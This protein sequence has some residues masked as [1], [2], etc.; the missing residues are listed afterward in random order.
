VPKLTKSRIDA[1]PIPESGQASHWDSELRGFG[2]RVLPSGLKT[3]VLQYRNAEAR[4]RRITLARVGVLTI[5]QARVEAR[6]KL[7]EIARGCDPIDTR[8]AARA[9]PTVADICDWY[10]E[11]AESGRLLGRR[12]LPIKASSLRMD[13]SRIERH[14]KPLIGSRKVGSLTPPDIAAM[15]AD[16]AAGKSSRSRGAGRGRDTTGGVGAGSRTISTLHAVFGH[17]VRLG[18]IAVNPAH[19]VRRLAAGQRTRRLSAA[20]IGALGDAMRQAAERGEHP[21]GL[22]AVRLI[23]LTGFRRNEAQALQRAWVDR[24]ADCV[25]F[26]DTKS[27]AQV[28]VVGAAAMELI[29]AQPEQ[30]G[31]P[32]VFPSDWTGTYYKQVPDIVTRLCHAAQVE[33]VT[34]HVFRHTFASI[35]GELGYSELTIAGL[36]GHGKRGV[37]QGY[38]HIDELL[39]SAADAVSTKIAAILDGKEQQIAT[40]R[41]SMP[42]PQV[43][44]LIRSSATDAVDDNMLLATLAAQFANGGIDA[45]QLRAAIGRIAA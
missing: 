25:M 29:E 41:K 34:P 4:S 12:R 11:E 42:K 26:P 14:I 2:V 16:I 37:T 43:Q 38:I 24:E 23:L 45:D 33:G 35:A 1:F 20:E 39:R 21:V 3:F 44:P 28:R 30:P 27:G 7:G 6:A 10:L 15:Q 17:A 32:Y 9:A 13:R 5:E 19:G 18:K 22:A 8:E 40:R 31:N 36:L